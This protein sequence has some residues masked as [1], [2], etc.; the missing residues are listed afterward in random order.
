[1]STGKKR[2]TASGKVS[3]KRHDAV[4]AA[5]HVSANKPLRAYRCEHCS[6]WH[7]TS[8]PARDKKAA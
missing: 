2:C 7:L 3:F 4:R 1:M 5:N 8:Q 6:R